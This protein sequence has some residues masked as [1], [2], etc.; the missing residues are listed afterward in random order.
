[1]TTASS[2]VSPVTLGETGWIVL[3]IV[4]PFLGVF[5]YLISQSDGMNQRNLEYARNQRADMDEYIRSTDGSDG[6][7][8]AAIE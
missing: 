2:G 7:A 5:L 1:M 4:L 8:A 6:G 3:T